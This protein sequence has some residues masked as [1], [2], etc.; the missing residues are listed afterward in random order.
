MVEV[1]LNSNDAGSV[2]INEVGSKPVYTFALCISN[3]GCEEYSD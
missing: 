1:E 3:N 2:E